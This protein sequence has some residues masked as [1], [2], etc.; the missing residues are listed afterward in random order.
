MS[1]FQNWILCTV[2]PDSPD[3][4]MKHNVDLKAL[5][6]GAKLTNKQHGLFSFMTLF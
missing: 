2:M 4:T 1:N 5:E 3:V 6:P